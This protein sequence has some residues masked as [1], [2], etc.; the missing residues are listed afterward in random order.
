MSLEVEVACTSPVSVLITRY[1]CL[2]IFLLIEYGNYFFTLAGLWPLVYLYEPLGFPLLC[3]MLPPYSLIDYMVYWVVP[4]VETG[5][6]AVS[7]A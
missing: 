2:P 3:G 1:V 7:C 4:L 5:T 6:P